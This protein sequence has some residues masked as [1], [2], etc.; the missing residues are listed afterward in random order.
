MRPKA[1]LGGMTAVPMAIAKQSMKPSV[2]LAPGGEVVDQLDMAV[3]VT[4]R[5]DAFDLVEVE[6]RRMRARQSPEG[7]G[8]DLPAV[9][10]VDA[11]G[12]RELRLTL[13][14]RRRQHQ[15]LP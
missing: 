7:V 11:S 3:A 6:R 15:S 14:H 1:G 13:R 4:Q 5:I 2:C 8:Q 10:I 12:D 9:R